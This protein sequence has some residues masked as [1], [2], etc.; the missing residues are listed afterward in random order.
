[1]GYHKSG[2]GAVG[3]LVTSPMPPNDGAMIAVFTSAVQQQ[4]LRNGRDLGPTGADG[5]WGSKT[6]DAFAAAEASIPFANRYNRS[7]AY[8]VSV[9]KRSVNL[10]GDLWNA[11]QR[12]PTIARTRT[13]APRPP[14][15]D[16]S[17]FIGPAN[18]PPIVPDSGGP[19]LLP[20]I[21][22]GIVL[23][24]IGAY[25][26]FTPG[27]TRPV[28]AN[29]RRRRLSAN[30]KRREPRKFEITSVDSGKT[31]VWTLKKA[32]EFFGR[33]EFQEILKGYL[34]H[35]VAVEIGRH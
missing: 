3:D 32:N 18:D 12:L 27:K 23:A 29:Q 13:P 28:A 33:E 14:A 17:T 15:D 6:N 26:Y 25:F 21:I 8:R 22:G 10:T 19:N 34:P 16:G 2:M 31:V 30:P 35:I 4:L 7:F 24:G 9:D 5:E 20:W 1:M 11:I